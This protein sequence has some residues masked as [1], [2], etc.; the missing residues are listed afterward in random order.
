[1]TGS[2]V[3]LEDQIDDRD[4]GDDSFGLFIGFGLAAVALHTVDV[5]H[6]ARTAH[7][8]SHRPTIGLA[9]GP[10]GQAALAVSFRF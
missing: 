9:P 7:A 10:R 4:L 2:I 6:A 3:A 8:K 5:V 1:M